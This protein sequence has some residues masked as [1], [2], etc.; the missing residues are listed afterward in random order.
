[1]ASDQAVIFGR[2]LLKQ[3]PHDDIVS[4]YERAMQAN[5]GNPDQQDIKILAFIGKHPWAL[6]SIDGALALLK[7]NSEVRRGL[8]V[9]F[10]ILE[11]SPQYHRYFLPQHHS[12]WYLL[13]IA[14]ASIR[15]V[16][17]AVWGIAL[18]KVAVR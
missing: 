5:N 1:M 17:R 8:Y 12:W 2:Y 4:L 9:M 11:A 18:V 6:S 16:A 14:G 15:A 3:T 7:P 10:S 13:T